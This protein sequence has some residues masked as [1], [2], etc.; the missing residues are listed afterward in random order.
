MP[1][2]RPF[3][4]WNLLLGACSGCRCCGA[5]E[6]QEAPE[7]KLLGFA[8]AW[9]MGFQPHTGIVWVGDLALQ[10]GLQ[11]WAGLCQQG[12]FLLLGQF[13]SRS[14]WRSQ[15]KFLNC[16]LSS[17]FAYGFASACTAPMLIHTNAYLYLS[18]SFYLVKWRIV[19]GRN[20]VCRKHH[21]Y[22]VKQGRST[23]NTR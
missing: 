3:A 1:L 11:W 23:P 4:N 14:F 2:T 18:D 7:R 5:L 22:L 9:A 16:I 17:T 20:L 10:M 15:P 21:I 13:P 19:L 12:S 8:F 6:G